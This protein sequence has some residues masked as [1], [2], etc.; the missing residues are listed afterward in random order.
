MDIESNSTSIF[1]R[2]CV[3]PM[4]SLLPSSLCGKYSNGWYGNLWMSSD[5]K[6]KA[7]SPGDELALCCTLSTTQ[8]DI[9][10]LCTGRNPRIWSRCGNC[11][12]SNGT[13]GPAPSSSQLEGKFKKRLNLLM[14]VTF[15]GVFFYCYAN[16][17]NKVGSFILDLVLKT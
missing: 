11:T 1:G 3:C 2:V 5:L 10:I 16:P 6:C 7:G 13:S 17:S 4:L 14:F 15:Q 12:R 8:P 9:W